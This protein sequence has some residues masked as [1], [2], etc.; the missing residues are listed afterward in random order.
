MIRLLLAEDEMML[1]QAIR[2]VLEQEGFTVIHAEDGE[3]ALHLLTKE[4]FD[5]A[6]LDVNMPK[7]DGLE[8]TRAL[9]KQLDLPILMLTALSGEADLITGF[10]AGVDDYL[11]KPFS[12]KE[13]IVRVKALLRRAQG[14]T[15]SPIPQST[16]LTCGRLRVDTDSYLAQI[17]DIPIPLTLTE[18]RV[19]A[20]LVT[21]LGRACSGQE[22]IT[23]V[24]G[25][26]VAE[27]EAREIL[28]VHIQHLRRKMK[29][30]SGQPEHIENVYG[31][32][33]VIR[34]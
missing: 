5:F 11:T 27:N 29:T 23:A 2:F 14:Q 10:E 9:R 25:Y 4:S 24:Q 30:K 28:R 20:Y 8:L 3:E 6:I 33:Y 12:Y 32:G 34:G 7:M 21:N 19:L 13:L 31:V 16:I 18:F 22:I 17:D 1:A 26:D 15:R